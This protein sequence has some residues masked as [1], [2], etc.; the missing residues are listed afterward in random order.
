MIVKQPY[1]Y[2]D[3]TSEHHWPTVAT[4]NEYSVAYSTVVDV[5][6]PKQGRTRRVVD[7]F[8]IRDRMTDVS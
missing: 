1:L 6:A 8:E 7:R 2:F 3:I 4:L 5:F